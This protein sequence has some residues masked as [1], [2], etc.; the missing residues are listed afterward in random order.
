MKNFDANIEQVRPGS[1]I[2][3][4]PVIEQKMS[5]TTRGTAI[6]PLIG[7]DWGPVGEFVEV[8]TD[9]LDKI[10]KKLGR[11]IYSDNTFMLLLREA[12]CNAS[13]LLVYI[14]GAGTKATVTQGNLK[15]TAAYGGTLGNSLKVVCTE[16]TD[17]TFD[18]SVYLDTVVVEYYEEVADITALIAAASGSYVVF[19]KVSEAVALA[20]F[21]SAN[22]SGGT[23]IAATNTDITTMLDKAEMI[24]WDTIAFPVTEESLVTALVTKI[25]YLRSHTYRNVQ[26]VVANTDADYEG[27]INVTNAYAI[28]GLSLTAAQATAWVAGATAG[29]TK[30]TTNTYKVVSNATSVVDAKTNEQAVAAIKNGEFFF[31]LSEENE[32]VVEY[33]INSLITFTSEKTKDYRKNRVIRVYDSLA[34]D[35]QA[36]FIPGKFDNNENGWI[37]MTGIGKAILQ[38]YEKA[39]AIKNVDLDND[40]YVDSSKS[41]DNATYF[42]VALQAVDSAE[43]LYFTIGTK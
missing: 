15:V 31:S 21:A 26:G 12:F 30:T 1:Y 18:V 10:Q 14:I 20:A 42:N 27:I 2:D 6:I 33:D 5:T 37:L 41:V 17:S 22:L 32:I 16:N 23:V 25:K 34:N 8:T 7:Y 43:K 4:K 19:E 38:D 39:G 11:S 24:K 29:A 13:K 28:D 40:F 36:Q 3:Y 9:N 35:L